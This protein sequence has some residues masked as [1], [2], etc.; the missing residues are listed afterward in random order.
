MPMAGYHKPRG[1]Y[2]VTGADTRQLHVLCIQFYKRL[3][4]AFEAVHFLVRLIEQLRG[5][6]IPAGGNVEHFRK[7]DIRV[8]RKCQTTAQHKY[9]SMLKDIK[10]KSRN[11]QHYLNYTKNREKMLAIGLFA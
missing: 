9:L 5:L 6:Y 11:N 3:S 2:I 4:A 10:D 8:N 7:D 1:K